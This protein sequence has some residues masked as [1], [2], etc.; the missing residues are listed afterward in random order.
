MLVAE[1]LLLP[2]PRMCHNT[3]PTLLVLSTLLQQQ[4]E[5]LQKQQQKP[6]AGQVTNGLPKLANGPVASHNVELLLLQAERVLVYAATWLQ[7]MNSEHAMGRPQ[8]TT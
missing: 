1:P 6:L 7:W 5:Q 3:T 4:H 2:T 8:Q